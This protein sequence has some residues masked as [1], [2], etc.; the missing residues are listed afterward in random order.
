MNELASPVTLAVIVANVVVSMRGFGSP[1][2]VARWIFAP[3]AIT[4]G[5]QWE[6][7]VTS[8]FLHAGWGHLFFNM[9]SLWSFGRPLEMVCG[10]RAFLVIYL[11]AVVGGSL[12][13]LALHR[14]D[15]SYRA[16]GASGGVS[17]V[18][19]AAI[20]LFPGISI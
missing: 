18:I 16:L 17:G 13:S 7:L 12:V 1:G 9:Y 8:A 11:A 2:F 5:R 20:F 10:A 6:R 15:R 3:T 14:G 19:F 4:E